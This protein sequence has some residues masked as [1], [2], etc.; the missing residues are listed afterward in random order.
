MCSNY[1]I[2]VINPLY[3][4]GKSII[5]EKSTSQIIRILIFDISIAYDKLKYFLIPNNS[6]ET[7]Y[8]QH[9]LRTTF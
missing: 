8:W 9:F 1:F 5:H 3:G 6:L 4:F 2:R 7:K